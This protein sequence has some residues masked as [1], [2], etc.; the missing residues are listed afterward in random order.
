[1]PQQRG[2]NN[3]QFFG[4][5]LLKLAVIFLDKA[6]QTETSFIDLGLN[7]LSTLSFSNSTST[8]VIATSQK[9]GELM[10]RLSSV[11]P[12]PLH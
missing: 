10:P 8:S 3:K 1:M 7:D 5:H 9:V 6:I 11:A 2:Y 12:P 4:S